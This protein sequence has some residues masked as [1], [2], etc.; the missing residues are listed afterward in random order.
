MMIWIRIIC[1]DRLKSTK[2]CARFCC[3]RVYKWCRNDASN[4]TQ[5]AVT[6]AEFYIQHACLWLR[7]ISIIIIELWYFEVCRS[8]RLRQIFIHCIPFRFIAN[9]TLVA[10]CTLQIAFIN[11]NNNTH[12][13]QRV[14]NDKHHS[15][16]C[17]SVS[18][19]FKL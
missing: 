12:I 9:C 11:N 17:V 13:R 18:C 3:C 16:I 4:S 15:V 5:C 2:L 10:L 1:P 8:I 14:S 6:A 7:L 19:M